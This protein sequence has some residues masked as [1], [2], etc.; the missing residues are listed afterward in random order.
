VALNLVGD[1][2][3][4]PARLRANPG[5]ASHELERLPSVDREVVPVAVCLD[6]PNF[7]AITLPS[8]VHLSNF[9]LSRAATIHRDLW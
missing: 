9:Y 3:P 1:P 5:T 8:S 7:H 6:V 2:N 4:P